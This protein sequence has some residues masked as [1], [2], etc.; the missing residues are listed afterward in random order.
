MI[1]C[2]TYMVCACIASAIVATPLS[3]QKKDKD[4]DKGAP[5]C[6]ITTDKPDE[7]KSANN[8]VTVAQIGG[9][10]ED[11]QKRLKI[12]IA[13]L[14]QN[15]SKYK[16][17]QV[18]HDYVLG[19]TLVRWSE[20]FP[21]STTVSKGT[22]GYTDGKDEKIDLLATADTLLSSAEKS[23]P[24]CTADIT[25]YRMEAMRP[26]AI[27][28][29][30]LLNTDSSAQ[31]EAVVN[32]LKMIDQTSPLSLYFQAM[33]AQHKKDVVTAADLFSRGAAAMPPTVG[34]DSNLKAALEL[35]AAQMTRLSAQSMPADQ[36]K[37][38]MLK[39]ADLYK[40]FLADFPKSPNA[41]DAQQGLAASM[42]ASGD[43]QTVAKL[44]DDMLAT[45]AN[46]T[47]AQLYDAGTQAFTSNQF[48][49]AV[50]LM[51]AAQQK[52]GWLRPGLYNAANVY[53]KAGDFDRML[54]SSK[55]LTQID[56]NNPDEY[57]L[58]A[59]AYQ[60]KAKATKDPKVVRAYNDSLNAAFAA[61]EKVKV[62]VTFDA[63][64]MGSAKPA[65][66]GNVENLSD[67][68]QKG[69]LKVQ[70][71][72][73]SGSP[74]ATQS[75]DFTLAP[76]EKKQFSVSGEGAGVVAYRYDPIP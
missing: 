63:F 48:A 73:E 23:N 72:N 65:V 14:T 56:P 36:K 69:T 9:R 26:L 15:P 59:L 50:K 19:Q 24:D 41:P 17:N 40:K 4:K 16:S 13:A 51:D 3:A 5:A 62:K 52:N 42:A 33:V 20:Q 76:K 30:A 68:P 46:Y 35:G 1:R 47:A 12:A 43:T 45:P 34:A 31:A 66:S 38:G 28:A 7:V 67:A 22:I 74:V 58:L 37:A 64:A 61:S 39:A 70:F 44:W 54:A 21:E 49:P 25:S 10:P 32:R 53:W 55:K 2:N 71:L 11:Q 57:Q 60:G 6:S 29:S 8:A 27:H 75:T 18:G